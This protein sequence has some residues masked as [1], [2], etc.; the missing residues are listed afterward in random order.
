V[1][2]DG[3]PHGDRPG[4]ASTFHGEKSAYV[5][6]NYCHFP[7]SPYGD[8][9]FNQHIRRIEKACLVLH[10]D[11]PI[12]V[13]EVCLYCWT[14]SLLDYSVNKKTCATNLLTRIPRQMQFIRHTG[15]RS[16]NFPASLV[17]TRFQSEARFQQRVNL[18]QCSYFE[19]RALLFWELWNLIPI[20]FIEQT[21][22]GTCTCATC[23]LL[24][25]QIQRFS[26][27]ICNQTKTRKQKMDSIEC[28][29]KGKRCLV[30]GNCHFH[31]QKTTTA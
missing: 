26:A 3:V 1:C 31:N 30:E 19:V 14:F 17:R 23:N 29:H 20:I 9:F 28:M 2:S 11:W 15:Q 21:C 8:C 4:S 12:D 24:P 18:K 7:C 5:G 22:Y 10:L 25:M 16:V 13:I 6:K 27:H